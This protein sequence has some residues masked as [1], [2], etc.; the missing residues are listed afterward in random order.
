MR[1]PRNRKPS[2]GELFRNVRAGQA[3]KT[4]P[5]S[6]DAAADLSAEVLVNMSE[7][8]FSAL[9]RARPHQVEA[10]GGGGHERR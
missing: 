8:D 9:L 4:L 5:A 7:R 2:A 3:S 1:L 10:G 6:R